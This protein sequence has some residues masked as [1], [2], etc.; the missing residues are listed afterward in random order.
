[1]QGHV[2][3]KINDGNDVIVL[4]LE[5]RLPSPHPGH[6]FTRA[7]H[8]RTAGWFEHRLA[9]RHASSAQHAGP[10]FLA[11]DRPRRD[12]SVE[13][14]LH[15]R[16]GIRRPCVRHP[17]TG[18]DSDRE[19]DTRPEPSDNG[20]APQYAQP[21][22]P[23]PVATLQPCG[24]SARTLW[25]VDTYAETS[26]YVPIINGSDTNFSNPYVLHYPGNGYPTDQPRPQFNTHR[27]QQYSGGEV[28]VAAAAVAIVQA[29]RVVA[30]VAA[31]GRAARAEARNRNPTP[32]RSCMAG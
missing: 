13:G 14:T 27:L 4:A 8:R 26:G 9:P 16:I 24:E 17:L 15:A 1:M 11:P 18:P 12:R 21:A 30:R 19:D 5:R 28:R 25:V 3:L 32:T 31:I 23:P 22:L 7:T 29:A 20:S 10:V 6:D 2:R